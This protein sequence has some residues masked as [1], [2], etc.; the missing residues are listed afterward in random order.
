MN[1]TAAE[2]LHSATCDQ[3]GPC[4]ARRLLRTRCLHHR[5][6]G[7]RRAGHKRPPGDQLLPAEGGS[8][9]L[10]LRQRSEGRAARGLFARRAGVAHCGCIVGWSISVARAAAGAAGLASCLH[11]ES[12]ALHFTLHKTQRA[13]QARC[14][15]WEGPCTV[16]SAM[17]ALSS[18]QQ[19]VPRAGTFA[20]AS[21]TL[22]C[23]GSRERER[24]TRPVRLVVSTR[25]TRLDS[26][27]PRPSVPSS[28]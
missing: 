11:G 25:G 17:R 23:S 14:L 22:R 9:R 12:S 5:H 18:P 3:P 4:G 1:A 26:P 16:T 8:A 6:T 20:V 27:S 10:H 15:P 28:P 13:P 24:A 7:P 21:P 2:L 19:A